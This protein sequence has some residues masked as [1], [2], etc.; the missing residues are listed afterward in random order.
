MIVRKRFQYNIRIVISILLVLIN[1]FPV[2]WLLVTSLK[3]IELFTDKKIY[4][5]LSD[6]SI[7]SY[8]AAINNPVFWRYVMNSAI[9]GIA[10]TSIVIILSTFGAYSLARLKF[11]GREILANSV[12]F[13]YMVPPV[14]LAIPIYIWMFK[15]GFLNTRLG[16]IF[17]HITRGLP[18]ALW[19]LRGFFRGLPEDLEDA[20]KIDGCG[21]MGIIFRIILPLSGGGIVAVATYTMILSWNDYIMSYMLI[22]KGELQ[23]LPVGLSTMYETSD[24][25]NLPGIMA[26]S[27]LSAIPV[28]LFFFLLQKFIVRG[29]TAGAVKG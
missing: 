1:F 17:G 6:I 22:T 26:G 11:P 27:V 7:G 2:Y 21:L 12:L 4:V 20:A 29:M 18:F 19:M 24:F 23:T 14:L 16:L 25:I 15:L 5:S 9:I 8:L 28:V 10:S 13:V 3:P